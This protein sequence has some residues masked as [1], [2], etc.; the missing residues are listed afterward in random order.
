M[1]IAELRGKIS[2]TGSNLSERMEDLLTSDVF[3]AFRYLPI[4]LGLLDFLTISYNR[5]TTPF[6]PAI[7]PIRANWSFWPYLKYRGATPCEPDVVIGLE[8]D[9]ENLHVVMVEAKYMSRKSSQEDEGERPNDQLAR[10]LHNLQLLRPQDLGWPDTKTITARTLLYITQD[11]TIPLS[12]INQS[13]REYQHKRQDKAEI[14][15]TSWRYLPRIL[16]SLT[17]KTDDENQKAILSDLLDLLLKKHLTMF[18]GMEPVKFTVPLETFIFYQRL[19]LKYSWP[20]TQFAL[21]DF[22]FYKASTHIYL[23]P[24]IPSSQICRLKYDY[25]R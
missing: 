13:L 12:E 15:W 1:T 11:A 14:F 25:R 17:N 9:D 5:D 2:V 10:E 23:W 22:C 24:E 4:H 7:Q 8:D 21:S 20:K 18:Y 19:A 6:T 3:G 16:E